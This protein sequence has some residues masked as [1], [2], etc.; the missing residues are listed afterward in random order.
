MKNKKTLKLSAL[1][2]GANNDNG[3]ITLFDI[4]FEVLTGIVWYVVESLFES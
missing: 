1:S 4:S 2:E 3:A